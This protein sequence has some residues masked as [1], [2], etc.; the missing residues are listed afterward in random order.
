MK[1]EYRLRSYLLLLHGVLFLGTVSLFQQQPLLMLALELLLAGSFWLCWHLCRQSLQPLRYTECFQQL[2]SEQSYNHR[3]HA[4]SDPQLQSLVQCYNDLLARLQQERLRIGEQQGL[5]DQLLEA[6]PV[7]VLVF[8]F[9]DRLSLLNASARQLLGLA[10]PLN[11]PLCDWIDGDAPFFPQFSAIDQQRVH[12]LLPQ[13]QQL[14]PNQSSLCSDS[15]GRRFRC[16][17]SQFID[18]GFSRR[19]LLIEELTAELHSSE[20]STFDKL[21]RVIAH[22]VNN[23][24]AV[25]GS[26]LQSVSNYQQQLKA[27]DQQDFAVAIA[28]VQKRNH[29]LGQFI[30]RCSQVVKMPAAELQPTDLVVL[31]SDVMYLCRDNAQSRGVQLQWQ[32]SANPVWLLLD[33]ALFSQAVLNIVKNALEAAETGL[34]QQPTRPAKV[35][36]TLLPQSSSWLLSVT[37]SGDLLRDVEGGQLFTPFF[38]TKKGGQGIGLVFVREVLQR[39]GLPYRLASTDDQQSCFEIWFSSNKS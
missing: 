36:L 28:A 6:S 26:V 39:H 9:D 4:N 30:D 19:F 35:L 5:L 11:R 21:V 17:C 12:S 2:L 22:E 1:T 29:S 38:T 24:V 15:E 32:L 20:K 23:T 27:D 13:L 3:L 37:D 16:Q 31:L 34:L 33:P 14:L 10:D 7:A 25:T 8:D 18:R